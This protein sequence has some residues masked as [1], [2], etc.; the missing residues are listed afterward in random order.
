MRFLIAKAARVTG[1]LLEHAVRE[2]LMEQHIPE[3]ECVVCYGAGYTGPLPALNAKCSGAG[4][5]EQGLALRHGLEEEALDIFP[6]QYAPVWAPAVYPLP[7]V[8]RR[9]KHTKGRDIRLC[10]TEKGVRAMLAKGKHDFVTPVVESDTEYRAWVY[11]NR[12]LCVYEKRLTEPEKNT[13]FGRNRD[14]GWT[15]HALNSEHIPESVRRVAITAVRCLD[16]DFGAVDILGKWEDDEHT[17]VKATVLEVNSA[18]GVSDEH[19]TA[20]VKLTTRIVKW[21]RAG[22]PERTVPTAV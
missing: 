4:K 8:A 1:E 3:P 10:R 19:R 11:R 20:F 14:N 16:L 18:P 2:A 21:I 9:V 13:K 6:L 22:C 5:M 7:V 12:V 15:F 17:D